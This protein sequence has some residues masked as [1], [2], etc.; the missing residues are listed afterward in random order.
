MA[1]SFSFLFKSFFFLI[2]KFTKPGGK[3]Q[4]RKAVLWRMQAQALWHQNSWPP[5]PPNTSRDSTRTPAHISL[6]VELRP[7]SPFALWSLCAAVPAPWAAQRWTPS[8]APAVAWRQ[9][10]CP[11]CVPS[12]GPCACSAHPGHLWLHPGHTGK[13]G[14]KNVT[15]AHSNVKPHQSEEIRTDAVEKKH[16]CKTLQEVELTTSCPP[17]LTLS[18]SAIPAQPTPVLCKH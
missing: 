13:S 14:I 9:R 6:P 17:G 7:A 11:C 16:S 15:A 1:F 4:Q 5:S 18:L 3:K 2:P 8:A 10:W 12:A